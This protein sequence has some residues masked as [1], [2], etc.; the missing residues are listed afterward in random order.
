MPKSTAITDRLLAKVAESPSGCWLWQA[1]VDQYGY[2]RI[3]I[4]GRQ[5]RPV[6]AHRVAYEQ[7]VGPIPDGLELDHL[8][9]MPA[10]V[11]PAHLEPVTRGVNQTRAFAARAMTRTHCEKGHELIAGNIVPRTDR[12]SECRTCHNQNT[13]DSMR[14]IRAA[15]T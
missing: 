6:A 15:R 3:K 12:Y 7:L 1:S 5:G 8:C 4:G 11:N 14:R 13:R 10:C 9:R 2:G